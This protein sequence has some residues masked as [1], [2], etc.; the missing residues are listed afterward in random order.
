VN[1][2]YWKAV[3]EPVLHEILSES[4]EKYAAEHN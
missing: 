4:E 3:L 2:V 1:F